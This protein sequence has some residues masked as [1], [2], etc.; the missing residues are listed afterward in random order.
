STRSCAASS[1]HSCRASAI[2]SLASF[3]VRR[4]TP[5][6]HPL[7]VSTRRPSSCLHREQRVG[8]RGIRLAPQGNIRLFENAKSRKS[9]I[10]K[11]ERLIRDP[12]R[13]E[14]RKDSFLVSWLPYQKA[15][16]LSRFRPF[17]ISRSQTVASFLLRSA[18][19][20]GGIIGSAIAPQS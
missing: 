10:A 14:A 1:F 17:A 2:R 7:F 15:P 18:Q 6:R 8:A 9:E 3:P 4:H 5:T 13:E 16:S 19:R 12:G 20:L 11:S